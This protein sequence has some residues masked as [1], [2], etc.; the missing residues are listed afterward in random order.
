MTKH[1]K[2]LGHTLFWLGMIFPSFLVFSI[3]QNGGVE[4]NSTWGYIL[5]ISGI[6]LIID[7]YILRKK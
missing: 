7:K 6:L 3:I 1:K 2:W 5:L 4:S